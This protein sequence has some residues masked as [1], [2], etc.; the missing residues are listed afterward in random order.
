MEEKMSEAL[1]THVPQGKGDLKN[2]KEEYEIKL[3]KY[4]V[5]SFWTIKAGQTLIEIGRAHV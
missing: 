5:D 1:D 3:L 4:Q 2:S